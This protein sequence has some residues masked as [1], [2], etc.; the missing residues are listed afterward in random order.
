MVSSF[1]RLGR[2]KGVGSVSHFEGRCVEYDKSGRWMCLRQEISHP[3][4]IFALRVG[5]RS[6]NGARIDCQLVPIFI[7]LDGMMRSGSGHRNGGQ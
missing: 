1:K 5:I 7:Q 4:E 2:K 3:R 6:E